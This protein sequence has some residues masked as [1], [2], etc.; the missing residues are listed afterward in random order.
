[1]K[2]K[3][4]VIP[5][6][7]KHG[8]AQDRVKSCTKGLFADKIDK[9]RTKTLLKNLAE[10]GRRTA[11]N[12]ELARL[13]WVFETARIRSMPRYFR[14]N[15]ASMAGY[16]PG[17]Q[18]G[19][20]KLAKLN[21]NENPYPPSPSVLAALRKATNQSLRLYP[22]PL[23]DCL[24]NVAAEVYGVGPNNILAGNGSDEILSIVLRCFV[25]RGD[26][27]AFPVPTYSLYET[28]V[29][30]QD[31]EQVCVG[32]PADFAIPPQLHSA[33]AAVTFLC[34]PNSPSGTLVALSEIDKLARAVA[35]V[36]VVDEAY[37]DFAEDPGSSA[38]SLIQNIPNLIVLRTFSKSFSLAGLRIGLAFASAEL[39]A[40]MMKVK[41]SYNLNRL[42]LVAATAALQDLPWMQRNVRRIQQTRRK[43]IDGLR[44][45]G[46]YVYPSHANFVMAQKKGQEQKALYHAL[47][48]RKI[49]VRYFDIPGLR[50]SLRITVGTA[51][52]VENLLQE[53]ATI[54]NAGGVT[55]LQTEGGEL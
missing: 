36:I 29:K 47:R 27:V 34:N 49:F 16:V 3:I 39:I 17:E 13:K 24:R 37:I 53:I 42:S 48:E 51:E 19:D 41:D 8:P 11:R 1:V 9:T 38:I 31:G 45:L 14:S 2:K 18:P 21:T 44:K 6:S 15:I 46:F 20:E 7:Y 32:Y 35:G 33:N 30:I 23:S 54:Q 25:G 5:V 50:D 26:R 43:L 28:L 4:R 22:E 55:L 40:G 52:E 10:F 12:S